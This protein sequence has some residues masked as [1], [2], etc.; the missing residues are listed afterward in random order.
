MIQL[1]FIGLKLNIKKIIN[2]G[3]FMEPFNNQDFKDFI[4][5][6][7][8]GAFEDEDHKI[9]KFYDT[10]TEL[11]RSDTRRADPLIVNSQKMYGLDWI[12]KDSNKFDE[13]PPK[14]TDALYFREDEN[15]NLILHI[16]E[17]KFVGRKSHWDKI[18]ILCHDIRKKIDCAGNVDEDFIE[19]NVVD[20][21]KDELT[22][23]DMDIGE[24]D[25]CEFDECFDESFVDD[26]KLI[27]KD[28]KDPIEV[29]LQLKPYEVIF[30][31]LPKLYEEY[32][33]NNSC[34]KKED[35][36]SFLNK[37]DKYYWTFIGNF[38]QNER[39]IKRKV[40]RYNLYNK[41]LELT[42]FKKARVKPKQRFKNTLKREILG[43][44]D[45]E[46]I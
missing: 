24:K 8:Y 22:D 34:V 29:S 4:E 23:E 18:N 11:S 5:S 6:Y 45:L 37:I 7:K 25:E 17:F 27:K 46:N 33:E 21:I 10:I 44:S 15:G 12:V 30:I 38:S 14:S 26:F 16:I 41:R 32:C 9:H 42:I 36:V 28:F 2:D 1:K 3:I 31:T 20:N 40:D 39:N 13:E 19:D 35:M 43:N